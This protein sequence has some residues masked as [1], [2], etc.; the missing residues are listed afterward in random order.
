MAVH[1]GYRGKINIAID[2]PAGA[3]KS[4]VARLV[5]KQL[6]YIYVD[7]GAMYRAVT[8]Q[9]I[10]SGINPSRTADIARMAESLCIQLL[11][12]ADKQIVLLNGEDVTELIRSIEVNRNVSAVAQIEEVRLKLVN[13]QQEMAARKG[14]V[15]DGRD[16]GT[17]VLPDAEV[18][19]FL[20]ASVRERAERRFK[21]MGDQTEV[22]LE[23]LESD[24]ALRDRMDEQREISPLV[25]AEDAYLLD[26]SRMS[27]EEVA[28]VIIDRCR[29]KWGEEK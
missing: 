11:P 12:G 27:I 15:M 9:A 13:A 23:Q 28:Q 2:G 26:S 14:V 17:H 19:I 22:T 1:Q 29:T 10:R 25:R 8:L 16:I 6:E 7:T 3:G 5:A 4:T 24:I 20:T 18:K 21:E